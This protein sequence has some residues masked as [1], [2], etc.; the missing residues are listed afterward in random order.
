MDGSFPITNQEILDYFNNNPTL[1]HTGL[2]IKTII[3]IEKTTGIPLICYTSKTSNIQQGM[4]PSIEDDDIDGFSDLIHKIDGENIDVFIIS[5][6]GYPNSAERIINLLRNKYKKIRFIVTGNAYSAATIMCFAA[7]EIIMH[8]Q[9]TLGPID[10]QING[11]PAYDIL[12]GFEKLQEKIKNEGI[13]L[14]PLY[15]PLLENYDLTLFEICRKAQEL[16]EELAKQYLRVY[17]FKDLKNKAIKDEK[18]K[19][20]VDYFMDHEQHKLHGRSIER[21][22]AKLKELN[23][24]DSESIKN[25]NGNSESTNESLDNLIL[26]LHNQYRALFTNSSCYKIFENSK[27]IS[28]ARIFQPNYK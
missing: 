3:E 28:L 27:G 12:K 11:I 20:I 26:S 10:P 14:L 24:K 23:I 25:D 4:R 7:D 19:R 8:R 13:N 6:G 17:M 16:S 22:M 21:K 1:T 2:R 9:G 18:I 15:L 5:N